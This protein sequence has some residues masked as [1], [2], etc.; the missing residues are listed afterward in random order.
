MEALFCRFRAAVRGV[1]LVLI[2]VAT[3]AMGILPP[4]VAWAASQT[5]ASLGAIAQFIPRQALVALSLAKP[6]Q[7]LPGPLG[8]PLEQ[9]LRD[10]WQRLGIGEL[11]RVK[12]WADNEMAIALLP[13]DTGSEAPTLH[14]INQGTNLGDRLLWIIKIRRNEAATNFLDRL[15]QDRQGN[16]SKSETYQGVRVLSAAGS[17]RLAN[18][19]SLQNGLPVATAQVKDRVVLIATNPQLIKAALASAQSPDASL[20]MMASYRQAIATLPPNPWGFLYGNLQSLGD[21][22]QLSPR[23]DR[24]FLALYQDGKQLLMDMA[25]KGIG[26]TPAEE[27]GANSTIASGLHSDL[28]QAWP[29]DPGM[30]LMGKAL[31]QA[32]QDL[33]AALITY[34]A[35]RAQSGES[36]LE[37]AIA[38]LGH[39]WKIDLVN[40]IFPLGS[41]AYALGLWPQ[42]PD[43]TQLDWLWTSPITPET[44]S[45]LATL[46][47]IA[48]D[49]G[50]SRDPIPVGSQ[51]FQAWTKLNP[52]LENTGRLISQ[53]AGV[54]GQNGETVWLGSSLVTLSEY[55]DHLAH[56]GTDKS[57]PSSSWLKLNQWGVKERDIQGLLY[58]NWSKSR[59]LLEHRFPF[60]KILDTWTM[61]LGEQLQSI[62]LINQGRQGPFQRARA[63]IEWEQER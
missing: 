45:T 54:Y 8:T 35:G 44:D 58:L 59:F 62:A 60:L 28:V 53:V 52:D 11:R 1:V 2:L 10:E 7:E 48:T 30:A 17:P 5:D 47:T 34:P 50:F 49:K 13:S 15:W 38:D 51:S 31:P 46:D 26:E 42:A 27:T 40:T 22:S 4:G 14:G 21:P 32:W 63:I 57:N 9:I 23:Y 20:G 29:A 36:I 61:P 18:P 24:L 43:S 33:N 3:L 37:R 16:G 12:D 39:Q 6:V 41:Q 56:P 19:K 25:L 55:F